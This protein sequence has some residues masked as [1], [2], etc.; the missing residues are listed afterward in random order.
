MVFTSIGQAASAYRNSL[1]ELDSIALAADK[2]ARR[3]NKRVNDVQRAQLYLRASPEGRAAISA[4]IGD[5]LPTV[6]HWAASHALFWDEDAARRHL[7]AERDAGGIGS[8]NAAMTLRE[9]DAGRLRHDW[10]PPA[11]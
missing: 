11:R 5:A 3:W 4:L 7:E 2:G 8:F 10:L 1:V 6:S 9:F